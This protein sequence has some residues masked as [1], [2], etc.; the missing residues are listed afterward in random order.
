MD[1]VIIGAGHIGKNTG[2][3]E[4]AERKRGSGEKKRSRRNRSGFRRL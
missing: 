1:A 4:G 3:E 2:V